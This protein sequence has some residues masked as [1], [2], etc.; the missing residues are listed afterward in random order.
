M[1]VSNVNSS[2][3]FGMAIKIPDPYSAGKLRKLIKSDTDVKKF[4]KLVT[5]QENNVF[6]I[7]LG[8]VTSNGKE[9][10]RGYIYNGRGF[11]NNAD[12][13]NNSEI[14]LNPLN[15]IEAICKKADEIAEMRKAR[16]IVSDFFAK[17][18]KDF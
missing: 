16:E 18:S 1:R 13:L 11:Y 12:G 6:D 9:R 8:F 5:S 3:T 15:F 4:A 14:T 17:N 10:L 7:N 2:P